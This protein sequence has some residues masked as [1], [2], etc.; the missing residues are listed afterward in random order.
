MLEWAAL[1]AIMFA[2]LIFCARIMR[3]GITSLDEDRKEYLA[4]MA[5][6]Q[7]Q[8]DEDKKNISAHEQFQLVHAA[9]ADLLRLDG[10]PANA[11]LECMGNV[12]KISNADNELFVE[13][14][15]RERMLSSNR[16]IHGQ[17]HW[18]LRG[19]GVNEAHH[20]IAALMASLNAHLHGVKMQPEAP[21]HISRRIAAGKRARQMQ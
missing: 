3:R 19:N 4:R 5:E 13:L 17:A 20:D 16:V 14:V 12:L 2:V 7:R 21:D 9:M 15:M 18:L 11:S 1:G 8:I 6:G 10:S